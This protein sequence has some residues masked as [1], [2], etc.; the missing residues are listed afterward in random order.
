ML[1]VVDTVI[2]KAKR[3]ISRGLLLLLHE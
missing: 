3:T 1:Y 2:H